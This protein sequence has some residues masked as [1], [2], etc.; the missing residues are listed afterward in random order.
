[1]LGK[2]LRSDHIV[3]RIM[4]DDCRAIAG[5]P[6]VASLEFHLKIATL[7][8]DLAGNV[9]AGVNVRIGDL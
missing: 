8:S 6:Y 3:F 7:G 4:A 5:L 1:M 2:I 9:T